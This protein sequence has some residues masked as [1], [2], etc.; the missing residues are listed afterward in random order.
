MLPGIV[1]AVAVL[2]LFFGLK[3]KLQYI[4]HLIMTYGFLLGYGESNLKMKPDTEM[5][6]PEALEN[7]QEGS[8]RN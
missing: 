2:S 6:V 4:F 1:W 8:G 3:E 5:K 7:G